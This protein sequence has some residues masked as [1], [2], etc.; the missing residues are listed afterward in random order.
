MWI[1]TRYAGAFDENPETLEFD[2][3]NEAQDAVIDGASEE[4]GENF[5]DDEF[6]NYMQ[7]ITLK[8]I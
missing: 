3:W 8:E 4:L 1:L 6:D 2:N 5:T 7:L